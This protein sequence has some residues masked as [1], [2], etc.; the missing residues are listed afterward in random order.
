[1]SIEPLIA[2]AESKDKLV[3][4]VPTRTR[5]AVRRR[6]FLSKVASEEIRSSGS[7]AVLFKGAGHI[8]AALTKW[9]LGERI[10]EGFLKRLKPP[11]VA[12]IWE[13]RVVQPTPQW[14]VFALFACPNTLIIYR[15]HTRGFLDKKGSAAW[16]SAMKGSA[17]FW[18]EIFGTEPPYRQGDR[19][20]DYVT[21][22]CDDFKV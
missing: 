15:S 16:K 18:A 2:E 10:Y 17:Q 1:M 13:I 3:R 14:R 12:D 8:E 20:V 7:A 4:F 6:A 11:P 19:S 5:H 22:N 21:E 9:V